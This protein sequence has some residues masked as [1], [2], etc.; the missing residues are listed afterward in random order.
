MAQ[1][2]YKCGSLVILKLFYVF[3]YRVFI[4]F[5]YFFTFKLFA[6]VESIRIVLFLVIARLT[7]INLNIL[8]VYYMISKLY[9]FIFWRVWFK[10][11]ICFVFIYKSS[12]I[13]CWRCCFCDWHLFALFFSTWF[14]DG[15]KDFLAWK[16]NEIN[17]FQKIKGCLLIILFQGQNKAYNCQWVW[18]FSF[19]YFF[20]IL[21]MFFYL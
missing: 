5:V 3:N 8:C 10:L 11:N 2:H 17:C 1:Y 6:C 18:S 21:F 7:V 14:K 4:T 13:Y 16:S 19:F 20:N 12:L 9:I 15:S